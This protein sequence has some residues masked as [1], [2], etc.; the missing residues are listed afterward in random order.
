MIESI[1]NVFLSFS[2][3]FS[4][5]V[6]AFSSFSDSISSINILPDLIDF[7]FSKPILF[8]DSEIVKP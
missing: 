5:I 7:T 1:F 3:I 2:E 8:A 4:A 6:L